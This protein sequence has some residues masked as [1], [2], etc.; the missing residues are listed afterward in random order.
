[1]AARLSLDKVREYL[2]VNSLSYLSEDGMLS[3][4]R[5]EK[6]D[7]CTACF[8]GRYPIPLEKGVRSDNTV[9]T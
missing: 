7:F 5:S 8:T 4:T 2:G 6:S 9:P 3:A 1:V